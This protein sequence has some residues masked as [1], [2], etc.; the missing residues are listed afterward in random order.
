[1]DQL[2][3]SF[4]RAEL[5]AMEMNAKH[6]YAITVAGGILAALNIVFMPADPEYANVVLSDPTMYFSLLNQMQ[7]M[8][9]ARGSAIGLIRAVDRGADALTV[10]PP[11][12]SGVMRQAL[13]LPT[14]LEVSAKHVMKY[15]KASQ[16]GERVEAIWVE[17]TQHGERFI[18]NGHHR[19]V[20]SQLVG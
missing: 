13:L 12:V 4:I 14:Q 6:A 18:L 3:G 20:A 9:G 7:L 8:L 19:Y 10:L 1:M 16:A 17:I 11:R 5:W 2:G 15:A